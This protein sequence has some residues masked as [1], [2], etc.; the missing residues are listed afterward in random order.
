MFVE[1]VAEWRG[2]RSL[3]LGRSKYPIPLAR[4]VGG[5]QVLG[6]AMKKILVTG[7]T[8]YIGSHTCVELLNAGHEVVVVDNL[9]N[10][11]AS[12]LDRVAK[13]TGKRPVFVKVDVCDKSAL[14]NVF[15]QYS[16]KAVIHFAGL[17]SIGESVAKPLRYYDN[18]VAGTLALCEVMAANDVRDL[19]FSSSATVYGN[20]ASVPINE[21]FPLSATNPYGR[22]KLIIEEILRDLYV[23]DSTLNIALLRYF[24]PVGAH[25]SGLIGEEPNGMPNNL[26]PYIAQVAIGKLAR[27]SVFGGDYPT[28]DGTGVRDYIHVVD[29]ALGHLKALEKLNTKPGVVTCNLGTG[30][31]YSV[32]EMVAAFGRAC[33]KPIPYQI[34]ARRPGDIAAC[35]ADPSKVKVELGWE[36]TRG[37]EAMCADAWRWQQWCSNAEV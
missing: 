13:I 3:N 22:S 2:I 6:A 33:G 24:N 36:A 32:L 8:G 34:V 19:V 26:L 17:K 10:S 12:V 1:W 16:I 27:L 15:A 21:S 23:A 37:L 25:E 31:G 7:G 29:L 20:P 11:K 14:S 28:P 18:N 30:R 9:C 5:W 35:Y 4:Q